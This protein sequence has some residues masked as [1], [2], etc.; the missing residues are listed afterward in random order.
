MSRWPALFRLVLCAALLVN[1][2]GT[3]AASAMHMAGHAHATTQSTD[4]MP[5]DACHDAGTGHEQPSSPA[6]DCCDDGACTTCTSF[7][8]ALPPQP[9]VAAPAWTTTVAAP[10]LA[11][12]HASAALSRLVRPPIR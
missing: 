8:H 12:G 11:D 9:L 5:A 2:V 10:A 1:A 3:A 6:P 7:V 4:A